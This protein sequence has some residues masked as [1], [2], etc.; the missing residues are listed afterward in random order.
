M[1]NASNPI[2][3]AIP[4]DGGHTFFNAALST[5][6]AALLQNLHVASQAALDNF[7][8]LGNLE[9]DLVDFLHTQGNDQQ[10]SKAAAAIIQRLVEQS[11][12]AFGAETAWVTLR[13]SIPNSQFDI[14]RWHTDGYFYEPYQGVQH[15]VAFAIKGNGTL[16]G[17]LTDKWRSAFEECVSRHTYPLTVEMRTETAELMTQ[18]G[19]I[20]PTLKNQGVIFTVGDMKRAA[21]HSEPPITEQRLFLSIVPGS[22]E[23]IASLAKRWHRVPVAR[24]ATPKPSDPA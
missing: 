12:D 20:H 22:H 9:S 16:F 7:A 15:K 1:K 6:E 14:P 5:A 23:Q 3:D 10:T 8:D 19:N 13:A 2:R 24:A 18:H 21:I 17:N 4:T 11:R